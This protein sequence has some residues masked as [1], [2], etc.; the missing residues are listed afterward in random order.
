VIGNGVDATRFCPVPQ[1]RKKFHVLIEG[2]LPDTNKNVLQAVEIANRVRQ[3]HPVEIWAFGK[4][5]AWPGKILDRAVQDPP[6]SEI[7]GFYQGCDV[8][9]KTSLME[10]FG[11][12]HLEA[13][14]CGCV[15]VTYASGGVLDFCRHEWNSMVTGV[16]NVPMMVRNILRLIADPAL[17]QALSANGVATARSM[18][19]SAVADRLEGVLEGKT[20]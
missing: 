6:Q 17:R 13:M 11:L 8:L 1:A 4:R 15:P 5:F 12:P 9:I 20:V 7:P 18:S 14:A 10:G 2:N 16:G 19:W 3:Y